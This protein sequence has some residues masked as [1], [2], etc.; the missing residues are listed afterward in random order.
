MFDGFKRGWSMAKS[1][2]AVLKDQPSLAVFPVISAVAAAALTA[3]MV[4]P[5]IL[6]TGVAVGLGLSDGAI[7]S[8][9]L[10]ALFVWYFVCTFAVVFCNAALIACALQR[11]AGQPTSVGSGFAAAGRRLPQILGWTL[12]ASTVGVVLQILQSFLRDKAGI[13]GDIMTGIA[14][15]LW[16][17]A[18]YFAV[19]VVVT[20]GLGPIDAIKRSSSVLRKTWGESLGGAAGLNIIMVLLLLPAVAVGVLAFGGAGG[21][22]VAVTIAALCILYAVVL[23]VVFSALGSIF[24]A[25]VYSY[26]TTGT[27]PSHMDAGLLQ[28]T[29]RPRAAPYSL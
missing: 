28:S 29:F 8:L 3:V 25:A 2:W 18:T 26:A 10:V 7:E 9:G 5:V 15:G 16:G 12:I 11:F 17:V 14:E 27:A 19:P 4:L 1:S 13:F 20:E 21:S 22:A 24:R 23:A 6:G